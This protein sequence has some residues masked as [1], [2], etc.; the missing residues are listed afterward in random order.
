MNLFVANGVISK[1]LHSNESCLVPGRVCQSLG[2]GSIFGK[3]S[4]MSS[5]TLEIR[6]QLRT[7]EIP[8]SKE[9]H[10]HQNNKP[11][12]NHIH[13]HANIHSHIHIQV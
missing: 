1:L 2:A 11:I 4:K 3:K 9:K 6:M 13:I 10:Q 5:E 12:P 7:I 8:V